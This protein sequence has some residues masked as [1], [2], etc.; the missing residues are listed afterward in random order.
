MYNPITQTDV[1]TAIPMF[2][3]G[4]SED[5]MLRIR[6]DPELGPKDEFRCRIAIRINPDTWA[7]DNII[8]VIWEL[9]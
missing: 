1:D 5:R 6:K 3:L 2:G 8:S 9:G 4:L 7:P